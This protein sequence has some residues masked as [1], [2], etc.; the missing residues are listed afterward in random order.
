MTDT[1]AAQA[2][3]EPP[4][5]RLRCGTPK[6]DESP[7]RC[8]R[9]LSHPDGHRGMCGERWAGVGSAVPLNYGGTRRCWCPGRRPGER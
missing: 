8:V 1:A 9:G 6:L 2:D 5:W 7:V 3:D 4:I